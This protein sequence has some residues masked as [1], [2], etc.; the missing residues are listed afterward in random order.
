MSGA[1]GWVPNVV[2]DAAK[3]AKSDQ[4]TPA[5]LLSISPDV[6]VVGILHRQA[7]FRPLLHQSARQAAAAGHISLIGFI[8]VEEIELDQ[9]HALVFKIGER[10]Q[11]SALALGRPPLA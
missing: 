3:G 5:K 10:P 11:D 9:L 6:P 8:V 2:T 1:H 7:H 4:L